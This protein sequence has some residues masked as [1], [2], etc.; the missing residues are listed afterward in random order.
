[1][2]CILLHVLYLD[3][4][5]AGS[6]PQIDAINCI[7]REYMGMEY[8]DGNTLKKSMH[9]KNRKNIFLNFFDNLTNFPTCLVFLHSPS[10]GS[11][12]A[13]V[14]VCGAGGASSFFSSS[15]G[16]WCFPPST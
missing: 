14:V 13:F 3:Q 10:V 4:K 12:S 15:L 16:S 5:F 1:M 9:K 6:S 7:P 11:G 8:R 2:S